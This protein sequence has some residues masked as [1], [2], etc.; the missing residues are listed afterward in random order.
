[1]YVCHKKG[2]NESVVTDG[3][4]RAHG[5]L[6]ACR[7][8]HRTKYCSVCDG[9]FE[10]TC[11]WSGCSAVS[12]CVSL[13]LHVFRRVTGVYIKDKPNKAKRGGDHYPD[14]ERRKN[15][16]HRVLSAGTCERV[17]SCTCA[18]VH[19]CMRASVRACKRA[20]VRGTYVCEK[21]PRAVLG[22]RL[23]PA[24]SSPPPP[25]PRLALAHRRRWRV[26][27]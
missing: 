11:P 7:G 13:I 24:R 3:A 8:G 19:A 6:A 5:A 26:R 25:R 21:Q 23:H 20:C 1:M 22:G 9:F 4:T 16:S 18:S 10:R 2:C 12:P 17:R 14:H 15:F 27:V